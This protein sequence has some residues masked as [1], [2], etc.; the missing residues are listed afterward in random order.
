MGE[1]QVPAVSLYGPVDAARA[2]NA[3]PVGP[4]PGGCGLRRGGGAGGVAAHRPRLA[5]A[6]ALLVVT[7]DLAM[8]GCRIVWTVPQADLDATPEVARLIERAERAGPVAGAVP[9]PSGR[10]VASRRVLPSA[11]AASASPSWSPGSTTRSTGCMPS[12]SACRTR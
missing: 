9:R 1:S 2:V 10:A 3:D 4:G 12:P 8:A 11:V 7:A 6:G 5:G